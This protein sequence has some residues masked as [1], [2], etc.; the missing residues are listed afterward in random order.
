MP[1]GE[2]KS[3]AYYKAGSIID[4]EYEVLQGMTKDDLWDYLLTG[5]TGMV[6]LTRAESDELYEASF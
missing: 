1:Q 3:D 2:A 5:F 6:A 4:S